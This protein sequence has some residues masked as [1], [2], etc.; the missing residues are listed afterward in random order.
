MTFATVQGMRAMLAGRFEEAAAAIERVGDFGRG[1]HGTMGA[2]DEATFHYVLYL[3]RWALARELGR[4]HEVRATIEDFVAEYPTFFIFRCLLASSYSLLGEQ[5]R[6]R[7]ELDRL[8]ADDFRGLD[9]GA[10][11]FFGAS[12][13]AE[14]CGS[15]GAVA[16]A[17]TLY[18]AL[19]PYGDFNAMAH[20][21]FSLGSASRYLGILASTMSLWEEAVAHFER[22]LT[23]N[24]AM[25]ARPW[26]AHTL[27][28]Y[29]RMLLARDEPGDR[30]RA[31]ELIAQAG[32]SYRELGMPTWAE[33][34]SELTR[35]V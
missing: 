16:H 7:T 34:A 3:Q 31:H 26:V 17:S 19:L 12:L 6:A 18:R 25:G 8:A 23:M 28:D 14:V 24:A 21:E 15:L 4:L 5:E 2:F 20:P 32:A 9:L 11:W 22:A 27:D 10:E 30:E 35:R 29:A 1:S 13:L 33:S